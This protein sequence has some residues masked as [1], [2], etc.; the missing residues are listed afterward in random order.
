MKNILTILALVAL[1][2]VSCAKG[3]GDAYVSEEQNLSGAATLVKGGE[4][5][6]GDEEIVNE[7]ENTEEEEGEAEE[8]EEEEGEEEEVGEEGDEEESEPADPETV[9]VEFVG[10]HFPE[11]AIAELKEDGEGFKVTLEDGT[12]INFDSNLDWKKISCKHS[13]VYTSVPA[14]V[15]PEE[16][17]AYLA[18]NYPENVVIDIKKVGFGWMVT[19]DG[20]GKKVK[21]NKDFSLK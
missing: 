4:E 13:S 20:K 2:L 19:L 1:F 5:A 16:I 8:G 15:I 10:T 17:N 12:Q 11:S 18:E 21:F 14:S 7:E 3:E 9:I 6:E